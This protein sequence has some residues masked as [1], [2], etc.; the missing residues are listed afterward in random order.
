MLPAI[1]DTRRIQ[2]AAVGLSFALFSA[3]DLLI[4]FITPAPERGAVLLPPLLSSVIALVTLPFLLS[5]FEKQQVRIEA[6]AT[7][8]E[9]LHAMDAAIF[10]EMEIP[11]LLPVV[12]DKAVIACDAEASGVVLFDPRT[13]A[14]SG[15]A[16]RTPD[17][18]GDAA[19]RFADLVR[20]GST[21]GDDEW[22]TL[23]VPLG[24]CATGGTERGTGYLLVAR[25]RVNTRPF[26][27]TERRLA[28]A[29]SS[30]LRLAVINARALSAAR[31]AQAVQQEL[32]ETRARQQ[33]D[34]AVA[35]ALTEGLL[36]EIPPAIGAW[37]FSQQYQAQ[38]DE[39]PVGGDLYDLFRVAPG[40]WGVFVADVSG[41]G[42]KAARQVALVKY[43]LRSYAREHLS[44]AAVLNHLN[45]TLFDEPEVTGF[46]TL[47]YA[48]LTENAGEMIWASAGHETPILRRASGAI[49]LLLP[50]GPVLGAMDDIAFREERGVFAPGDGLLVFTDGLSEA[51]SVRDRRELLEVE[52]VG[53]ELCVLLGD[54]PG[55]PGVPAVSVADGMMAALHRFTGGNRSDDTAV[56][57]MQF[58]PDAA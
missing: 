54:S 17:C 35:R 51:R 3:I 16:F 6:Q 55:K 34:G 49:E 33:R 39:A 36:P 40:K 28:D 48:V 44:P 24:K 46:V 30:T 13:G 58:A 22:E 20:A 5:L 52:G 12:A 53:R 56:L 50:T 23:V 38:S 42:L 2:V 1:R 15:E 57:W 47:F 41:K 4:L 45:E 25:R 29:L 31:D 26:G 7:E 21:T 32:Q 10:S 14:V 19:A 8:I 18:A 11:R 9:T 27:G 37:R 43:A